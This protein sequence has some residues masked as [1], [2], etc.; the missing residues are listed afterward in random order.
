MQICADQAN[1]SAKPIPPAKMGRI[2]FCRTHLGSKRWLPST[3]T[4]QT[5]HD[6]TVVQYL[7]LIWMTCGALSSAGKLRKSCQKTDK[8]FWKQN[9]Q[10]S[11]T[12]FLKVQNGPPIGIYCWNH[13]AHSC[14]QTALTPSLPS[15]FSNGL[16]HWNPSSCAGFRTTDAGTWIILALWKITG[17]ALRKLHSGPSNGIRSR[18]TYSTSIS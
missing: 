5:L 1:S 8:I 17:A 10:S 13:R 2:P 6:K 12:R 3:N 11:G 18:Q 7:T 16:Y 4:P 14:I 15:N 9:F